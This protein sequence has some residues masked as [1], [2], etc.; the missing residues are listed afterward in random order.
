MAKGGPNV[1]Y[2][3][4]SAIAEVP[5]GAHP[6][7]CYPN[8]AYDRA[9]IARYYDAAKAGPEAFRERYL[10]PFVFDAADPQTYLA[11]AGGDEMLARIASW[12]ESPEAWQRLFVDQGELD[13]VARAA[14]GTAGSRAASETAGVP[15]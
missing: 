8:Y 6:T 15:A 2:F 4:V 9:H 7:A 13:A 10:A 11:R 5:F 1:P 12:N 3:Y 14:S